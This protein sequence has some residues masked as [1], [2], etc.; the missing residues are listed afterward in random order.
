MCMCMARVGVGGEGEL[1]VDERIGFGF[2]QSCRNRGSVGR[3][4][5]LWLRWCG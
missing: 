2:Y 1:V 4:S 5:V 3:V